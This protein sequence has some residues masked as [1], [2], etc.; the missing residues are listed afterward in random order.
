MTATDIEQEKVYTLTELAELLRSPISVM[1]AAVRDKR[2]PAYKIGREYRVTA[3]GLN[4]YL[5]KQAER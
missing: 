3:S 4:A 5:T 1:R 2:L